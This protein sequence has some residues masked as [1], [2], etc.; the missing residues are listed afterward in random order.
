LL[1]STFYADWP[2]GERQQEA[3]Q[4]WAKCLLAAGV[5][6]LSYCEGEHNFLCEEE[7]LYEMIKD[8]YGFIDFIYGPDPRDWRIWL[9]HSGDVYVGMFW[10]L[11]ESGLQQL[12]GAWI[13]E[14]DVA[15][16]DTWRA[17]HG[18]RRIGLKRRSLRRLWARAKRNDFLN[19]GNAELLDELLD[20]V[21]E[22]AES[23][24]KRSG[25]GYS[26]C[27]KRMLEL[28]TLLGLTTPEFRRDYW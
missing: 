23:F 20:C 4:L 10:E 22:D 15:Q 6:L 26:M 7:A 8:E 28:A 5:D 16:Y 14:D 25:N 13:G 27:A 17:N 1:R 11:V 24:R 18:R 3:I 9:R 2:A 12:P 21:K 19:P